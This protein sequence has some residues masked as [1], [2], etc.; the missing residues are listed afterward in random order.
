VEI[1]Q[2]FNA[3]TKTNYTLT[4]DENIEQALNRISRDA[5]RAP[6]LAIAIAY[7]RSLPQNLQERFM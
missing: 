6:D 3:L 1:L 4:D 5:A 7:K 2:D